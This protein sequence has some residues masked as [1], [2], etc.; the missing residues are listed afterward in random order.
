MKKKYFNSLFIFPVKSYSCQS[1]YRFLKR[2]FCLDSLRHAHSWVYSWSERN[3]SRCSA[4]AALHEEIPT[5]SQCP[6]A[7][8]SNPESQVFGEQ[9]QGLLQDKRPVPS[10]PACPAPPP[11]A[12]QQ[13]R[14]GPAAEPS[15]VRHQLAWK[16]DSFVTTSKL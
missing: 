8:T 11:T 3:S 7:H 14:T 4:E 6:P 9:E 2:Q 10:L 16:W 15:S 1:T 13:P 12:N 5:D